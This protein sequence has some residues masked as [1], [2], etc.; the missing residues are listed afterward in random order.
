MSDW[1]R[2][3]YLKCIENEKEARR[4]F[5]KFCTAVSLTLII[6]VCTMVG[7]IMLK[8]IATPG[9]YRID[10]QNTSESTSKIIKE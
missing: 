6:S 2:D 5:F 7:S 1:E 10:V 3:A 9:D 8:W 4:S